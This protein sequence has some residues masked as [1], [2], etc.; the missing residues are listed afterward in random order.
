VGTIVGRSADNPLPGK[1]AEA[2]EIVPQLDELSRESGVAAVVLRI[3]SPGGDVLASDLI[4]RAVRQLAAHKPVVVSMGDRAASGAYYI[5]VGAKHIFAEPNTITGSIGVWTLNANLAPLHKLLKIGL[6]NQK[7]GPHADLGH[8]I[9]ELNPK[10]RSRLKIRMQGYY[11]GFIEK[12]AAGRHMT[13]DHALSISDGRVYTG[14]RAH[15]LGLVD[16]LG[17]LGD[18]IREATHLAGLAEEDVRVRIPR[19]PLSLSTA[20]R[21]VLSSGSSAAPDLVSFLGSLKTR[22]GAWNGRGLALMV[23]DYRLDP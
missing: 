10:E 15:E 1:S 2:S 16:S 23:N 13:T 3:N 19:T 9:R 20:I 21:R 11:E 7:T 14:R 22:V 17:S 12:V 6:S 4:W 8:S 18:A 5:A